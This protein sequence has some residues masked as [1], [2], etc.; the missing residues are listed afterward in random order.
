MAHSLTL[1]NGNLNEK[2]YYDLLK[3][4][5]AQVQIDYK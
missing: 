3:Q 4:R 1:N 5:K 2:K